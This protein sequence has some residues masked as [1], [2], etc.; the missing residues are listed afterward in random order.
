MTAPDWVCLKAINRNQTEVL[1]LIILTRR[2]QKTICAAA[3]IESL[4]SPL[5]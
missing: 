5:I 4:R 2:S 3:R 1:F